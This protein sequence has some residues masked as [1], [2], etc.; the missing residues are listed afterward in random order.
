MESLEKNKHDKFTL[1]FNSFRNLTIYIQIKN[2]LNNKSLHSIEIFFS[3]S[4]PKLWGE[5]M[6]EVNHRK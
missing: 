3:R 2:E 1:E 4:C 6:K 5:M